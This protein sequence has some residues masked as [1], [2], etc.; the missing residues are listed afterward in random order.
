[1]VQ[2]TSASDGAA[3]FRICAESARFFRPDGVPHFR[4]HA[5]TIEVFRRKA[6]IK[7]LQRA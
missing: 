4:I 2:L 6:G 1:M 5:A 7:L 3:H